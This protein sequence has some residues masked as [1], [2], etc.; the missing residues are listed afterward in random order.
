MQMPEMPRLQRF[1]E[2]T[3][4]MSSEERTNVLAFL[5]QGDDDESATYEHAPQSGEILGILKS[6]KDRMETDLAEMR[7]QEQ[8]DHE[9]FTELKSSKTELIRLAK[10]AI[11]DKEKRIGNLALSLSEG[12]HSL[13]DA[14]EELANAQKF[15]ANIAEECGTKMKERD[16]RAKMRS[17]EIAA[18]S[19]AVKILNDDD[20]LETFAKQKSSLV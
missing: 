6:M 2:I 16:E 13:G 17:A 11:I 12:K 9:A 8:K 4:L 7:D 20:A 19:D 10:Q 3:K 5:D 15:K 1:L 14:Q 18:I